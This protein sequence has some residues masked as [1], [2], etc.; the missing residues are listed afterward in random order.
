MKGDPRIGKNAVGEIMNYNGIT[1]EWIRGRKAVLT[2]YEDDKEVKQV[3]M[4]KL[5][6]REE[7]HKLMVDEGFHLKTQEDVIKEIQ[8][9]RRESQLRQVKGGEPSIFYN[10]LTAIYFVAFIVLAGV[11]FLLRRKKTFKR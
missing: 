10:T 3:E 5:K 1:I 8:V 2:I 6:T 9:E 11:V 4:Y 7:M